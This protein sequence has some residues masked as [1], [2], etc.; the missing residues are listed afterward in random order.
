[1]HSFNFHWELCSVDQPWWCQGNHRIIYKYPGMTAWQHKLL[2]QVLFM[3]CH[4]APA[5]T[6]HRLPLPQ[7]QCKLPLDISLLQWFNPSRQ[8]S[9]SQSLF[10]SDMGRRTEGRKWQSSWAEIRTAGVKWGEKNP[11]KLKGKQVMQKQSLNTS[12]LMPSQSLNND[13]PWTPPQVRNPNQHHRLLGRRLT[14]F[15]PEIVH[16]SKFK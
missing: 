6:A 9:P 15:Q 3:N 14:A 13:N 1:M 12:W 7:F 5:E 10:P 11:N 2:V 8:L 16:L 4:T